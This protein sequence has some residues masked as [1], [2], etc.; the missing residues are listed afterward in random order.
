MS[1]VSAGRILIMPLGNYNAATPYVPL[2]LV[3]YNNESWLCRKACTGVTPTATASEY[4]QKFGSAVSIATVTTAGIVRPDG[5]SV[6]IISDGT[7]S[8]P[9]A[10]GSGL[11]IVRPDGTTITIDAN[12]VL[13]AQAAGALSDLTDVNISSATQGQIL[14]YNIASHKWENVTKQFLTELEQMVD[15]DIDDS[16][17]ADGQALIYDVATGKWQNKAI[18]QYPKL[19]TA[20]QVMANTQSGKV[21][22]A[23]AIK[24]MNT[25]A[26]K[27][28][29]DSTYVT[30][31]SIAYDQTNQVL[32][33]KVNGADTV[34]PFKKGSVEKILEAR[35]TLFISENVGD[36]IWAGAATSAAAGRTVT[37]TNNAKAL[38]GFGRFGTWQG[39]A[40]YAGFFFVKTQADADAITYTYAPA[41]TQMTLPSGNTA[42]RVDLS[43]GG[44]PISGTS[45]SPSGFK[46]NGVDHAYQTDGAKTYD[47][48]DGA[49]NALLLA[50]VDVFFYG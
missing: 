36:M 11:G 47:I 2:D 40:T 3:A 30:V 24:T 49:L 27:K 10:T 18:T 17:L 9:T 50:I 46:V 4:W 35:G 28:F 25:A 44:Y 16:T 5:A 7:I 20:E 13:T 23:L 29:S 15:V 6:K 39:N 37:R 45:A 14:Q 12:G 8:V 19:D 48:N 34:I 32:G 43:T 33:L 38:I 21:A 22:D 1:E 42:W 41:K 26:V 31:D